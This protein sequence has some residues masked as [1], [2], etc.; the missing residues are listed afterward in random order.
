MAIQDDVNNLVFEMPR[1]AIIFRSST[2]LSD[3]TTLLGYNADPNNANWQNG[4]GEAL[5]FFCPVGTLYVQDNGSLWHKIDQFQ[6]TWSQF[7][8]STGGGGGSTNSTSE[9]HVLTRGSYDISSPPLSATFIPMQENTFAA[10]TYY[11]DINYIHAMVLPYDTILKRVV[12]RSTASAANNVVIGMHTNNGQ[13]LSPN[14]EYKF[15]PEVPTETQSY[16]FS[17]NNESRVYTFTSA[18]SASAGSTLGLSVS[19]DG[20]IGMTNM[21]IVLEYDT[22]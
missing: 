6:G 5:L 19:A 14:L 1:R 17:N 3:G 15:F 11:D 2:V 9:K 4:E 16:T 8:S 13:P 21:S 22:T 12:L 20:P 7:G 10:D 18:A